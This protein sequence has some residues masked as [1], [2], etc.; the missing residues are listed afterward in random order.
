MTKTEYL[1]GCKSERYKHL[2]KPLAD[3]RIFDMNKLLRD[4]AMKGKAMDKTSDEYKEIV[5]RYTETEKGIQW[6]KDL[7]EEG[8]EV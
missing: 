4:L 2:L 3:M 5:K 8:K 7:L 6:W 1:T